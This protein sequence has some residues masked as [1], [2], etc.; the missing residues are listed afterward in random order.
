M[1]V[2]GPRTAHDFIV[3]D[4]RPLHALMQSKEKACNSAKLCALAARAFPITTV[5]NVAMS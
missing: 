1:C 4:I 2:A 3:H 5:P